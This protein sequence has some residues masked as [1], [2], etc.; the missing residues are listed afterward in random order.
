M[1]HIV[2]CALI[3]AVCQLA[4][5][6]GLEYVV[7]GLPSNDGL[8]NAVRA[9]FKHRAYDSVLHVAYW[10]DGEDSQQHS[11]TERIDRSWRRY[12]SRGIGIPA[13][14]RTRDGALGRDGG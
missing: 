7:I 4:R 10:P 1:I 14:A 2:A 13:T 6:R 9:A 3:D 12:D 8:T 11:I 5:S